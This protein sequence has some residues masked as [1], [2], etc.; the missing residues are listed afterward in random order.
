MFCKWCGI[1]GYYNIMHI[2][3]Y[4]TTHHHRLLTDALMFFLPFITR[5]VMRTTERESMKYNKQLLVI[6]K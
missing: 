6:Q 1:K 5:D 2:F 4:I 3:L